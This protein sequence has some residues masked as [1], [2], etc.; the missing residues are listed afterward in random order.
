M[1]TVPHVHHVCRC[2]CVCGWDRLDFAGFDT[3]CECYGRCCFGFCFG[4]AFY[5]VYSIY[6]WCWCSSFALTRSFSLWFSFFHTNL[7]DRKTEKDSQHT[8]IDI[9]H[10]WHLYTFQ[11][12]TW[13]FTVWWIFFVCCPFPDNLFVCILFGLI[14]LALLWC[15][16]RHRT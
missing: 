4:F 2:L 15:C 16:C 9:T 5:R 11:H 1:H 10:N 14:R 8:W 12:I 7:N 13:I 3:V 6:C